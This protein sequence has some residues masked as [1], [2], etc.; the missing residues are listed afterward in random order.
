M[1]LEIVLIFLLPCV[2]AQQD[3]TMFGADIQ[4]PVKAY[5]DE[6]YQFTCANGE[7]IVSFRAKGIIDWCFRPFTIGAMG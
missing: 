1:R 7:C 5:C 3:D 6:N 2:F 4:P